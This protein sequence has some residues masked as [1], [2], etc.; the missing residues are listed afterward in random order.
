MVRLS[1]INPIETYQDSE[2]S[3]P[4]SF[5]TPTTRTITHNQNRITDEITVRFFHLNNWVD[6]A[7]MYQLPGGNLYG[8][9]P[10]NDSG[11]AGS[12]KNRTRI[13]FYG[14]LSGSTGLCRVRL[15]WYTNNDIALASTGYVS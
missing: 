9:L 5:V 12:D 8:Y 3:W 15:Y 6:I 11:G 2:F 7:G 4:N 1:R 13:N 14:T 10:T